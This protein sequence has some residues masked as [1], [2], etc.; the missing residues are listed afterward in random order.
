M[1][2]KGSLGVSCLPVP[3][4]TFCYTAASVID[5]LSNKLPHDISYTIAGLWGDGRVVTGP[6]RYGELPT[7]VSKLQ[8]AT[9]Q[10]KRTH[11]MREI[12]RTFYGPFLPN[13]GMWS[14]IGEVLI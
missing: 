4:H 13:E 11:R 2:E 3:G 10:C 8:A 9:H 1:Y 7:E 12:R 6:P 14:L 5:P